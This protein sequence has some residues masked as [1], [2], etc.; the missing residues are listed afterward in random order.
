MKYIKSKGGYYFKEYKNDTIK[1][2]LDDIEYHYL[3][4]IY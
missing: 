2:L 1:D 4:S 3:N